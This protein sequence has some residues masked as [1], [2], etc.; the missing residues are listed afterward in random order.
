M[1]DS[2]AGG[3]RPRRRRVAV[4]RRRRGRVSRGIPCRG[5]WW[6]WLR[7]PSEKYFSRPTPAHRWRPHHGRRRRGR[8]GIADVDLDLAHDDGDARFFLTTHV[9][10]DGAS[11][12]VDVGSTPDARRDVVDGDA[13]N[14]LRRASTS[15]MPRRRR[16]RMG[17]SWEGSREGLIWGRWSP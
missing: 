3:W 16:R 17:S 4:P 6:V 5:G 1:Q 7:G 2:A 13:R 12:C 11:S 10:L 8:H 14:P 15:T 9:D